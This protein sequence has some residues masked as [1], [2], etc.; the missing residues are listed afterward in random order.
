MQKGW[1]KSDKTVKAPP[2]ERHITDLTLASADEADD[3]VRIVLILGEPL[4]TDH[5]AETGTKTGSETGEP[6][7]IDS[8]GEARGPKG[9]SWIECV[10]EAWVTAIEKLVK[11]QG[12]LL[13]I[14]R[15]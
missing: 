6:E 2:L 3:Q 7:A 13:L 5:G 15:R 9:N 8:D 14:I 1:E 10:S 12:R 11:E 4:F